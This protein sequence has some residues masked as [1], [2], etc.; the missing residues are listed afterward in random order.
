MKEKIKSKSNKKTKKIIQ[1]IFNPK[2]LICLLIAWIIT[3]GW[4]YIFLFIGTYFKIGWMLKIASAYLAFIWLP[5]T[6]EKIITI[7][8]SIALLQLLFPNDKKTLSI[9]K[10]LY[11]K[12][13]NK[14]KKYKK[15]K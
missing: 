8:F 10:S 6:P 15:N 12:A 13:K 2:L 4:S 9:L 5:F 11:W 7:A 3:N 14:I 1:F